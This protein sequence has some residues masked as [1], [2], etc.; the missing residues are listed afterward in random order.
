LSGATVRASIPE[1]IEGIRA[2]ME[3]SRA[4]DRIPGFTRADIERHLVRIV[5][6]PTGTIV[7]ATDDGIVAYCTPNHDDLTVHPAHRRRGHGRRLLPATLAML[8][9]RGQADLQLYVPPHLPA[10][11]AFAEALGFCYRSSL[12]R[13]ELAEGDVVPPA[14]FPEDVLTRP[15]DAA[16]D[17]DI[18]VWVA[19]MLATF[20]GHPT[21][22]TWTPAV[23]AH[24]NASPDFDPTG[25]L[26]VSP[27]SDPER[28][29]AFTR[30]ELFPEAD[31]ITGAVGLIGVL[32]EWRGRGLGREL[33]RWGVAELRR[34]GAGR[35]ELSVEAANERAT[36]LYRAHGFEPAI[37]WPHWVL[38]TG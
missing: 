24:V 29:I 27:E 38:P 5:P 28:P 3:A 18:D 4:A 7:V 2:V 21:A 31:A 22:M 34:R 11:V 12:W 10:S 23:I 14:R 19:F 30:I 35:V 25:I 20:E 8:R 1:D 37:E 13:F 32:P 16:R 33:L 36:T 6:D 17:G 26:I 15:F 9:G